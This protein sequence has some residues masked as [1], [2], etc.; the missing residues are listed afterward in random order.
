ML[1]R[2]RL[3]VNLNS[4]KLIIKIVAQSVET[5]ISQ[6]ECMIDDKQ[7]K[8]TGDFFIYIK[9]IKTYTKGLCMCLYIIH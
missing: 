5:L 9:R 1:L 3:G 2:K 6:L 7:L 8:C 4:I